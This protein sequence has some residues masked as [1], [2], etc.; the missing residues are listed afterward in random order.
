MGGYAPHLARVS[1]VRPA[2]CA[3]RLVPSAAALNG[4]FPRARGL[5]NAEA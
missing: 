1:A 4:G 2:T 3:I 5:V